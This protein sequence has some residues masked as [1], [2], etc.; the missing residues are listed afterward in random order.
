MNAPKK[1][2]VAG[3]PL[4]ES[5][6]HVEALSGNEGGFFLAQENAEGCD[7]LR[8][9]EAWNRYFSQPLFTR[10]PVWI[11]H[12]ITSRIDDAGHDGV[13]RDSTFAPFGRKSP[14]QCF[15]LLNDGRALCK[16]LRTLSTM[17]APA[18]ANPIAMALPML[19][20]EPVTR[21]VVFLRDSMGEGG[22]C[23]RTSPSRCNSRIFT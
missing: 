7:F 4:H 17:F 18:L 2:E 6:I 23:Y 22:G 10:R 11:M 13:Y 15:D 21:A 12:R 16:I 14:S 20:P 19:R 5:P 8:G 1:H 3:L 9:P